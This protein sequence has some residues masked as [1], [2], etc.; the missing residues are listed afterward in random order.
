MK[1]LYTPSKIK[2]IET[3][4]FQGYLSNVKYNT[5][6]NK[7]LHLLSLY[8]RAVQTEVNDYE[9]YFNDNIDMKFY[10]FGQELEV[11]RNI[12]IKHLNRF[13]AYLIKFN[14]KIIDKN[15]SEIIKFNNQ[16]IKVKIDLVVEYSDKIELV[17]LSMSKPA[18]SY[19]ARNLDNIPENN[20]E[21][22]LMQLLGK[23][24]YVKAE[25]PISSAFYHMTGKFDGGKENK[26]NYNLFLN[27]EINVLNGLVD[28]QEENKRLA[29]NKR[30]ANKCDTVIKKL[31][32]II[33]FDGEKGSH[34]IRE[35]NFGVDYITDKL[36]NVFNVE[37]SMDSEK[38]VGSHC[39]MCQNYVLCQAQGYSK[40]ELEVVVEGDSGKGKVEATDSQLEFINSRDKYVR[41]NAVGGS[42]KTF[43]V[44][45]RLVE[46]LKTNDPSEILL[47]TFTNVGAEEMRTK[48]S[49]LTD[50]NPKDMNI[51]TFNSLGMYIIENE[52][53]VLG[54][55]AQPEL[56]N[57]IDKIDY[58][59][60]LLNRDEYKNLEWLNYKYPMLNMPNAKGAV[61]QVLNMFDELQ[62][63]T[64]TINSDVDESVVLDIYRDYG[65]ILLENNQLDYQDQLI[66]AIDALRD[67]EDILEKYGFKF[68]LVDEYNDVNK[69]QVDFLKIL[70]L[71]KTFEGLAILGD[72]SQSVFAFN[73]TSPK[74]MINFKDYFGEFTDIFILDNFR[75][76]SEIC[77][78]CN[79]YIKL[80][81]NRV[82]K[83][84][85]SVRGK[86]GRVELLKYNTIEDE[87][88]SIAVMIEQESTNYSDYAILGRTSKE[89]L[90]LKK[91]LDGKNIP[92][93]LAIPQK[94]MDNHNIRLIINLVKY[95]NG[96]KLEDG[97][98]DLDKNDYYLFEYVASTFN[99][100]TVVIYEIIVNT[101]KDEVK[102]Y[103]LDDELGEFSIFN[104]LIEELTKDDKVAKIF[105]NN[106]LEERTWSSFNEFANHL[107]KHVKYND[108]SQSEK[109][110][111]KYNAVILSTYHSS[112][113]KE[114]PKVFML[115]DKFNYTL[116]TE[117]DE[118]EEQRRLAYVGA[119]RSM[120]ELYMVYNTNEEAKRNKG[121]YPYI[122]DE[123]K[124]ILPSQIKPKGCWQSVNTV[125]KCDDMIMGEERS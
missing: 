120:N 108:I 43:A 91:V 123:I 10:T 63:G 64:L 106:L 125:D 41:V 35:F 119:S 36:N 75:S 122:V 86:G 1:M 99:N 117:Q 47:I 33:D 83:E 37:L 31:K 56:I 87:Y 67:N 111:I 112:K 82:D 53:D 55:T 81:E 73:F 116:T 26:D 38:C 95:I 78:L 60:E 110:D 21:L 69:I 65:E 90:T 121:K 27:G 22:Y 49:K 13:K 42:G 118:L 115:L 7:Y 62:R 20:F 50:V 124:N 28:E 11:D 44:I 30:A 23:D 34:I 74:F 66:L 113:G 39:S 48:L 6:Q 88:N 51:F 104:F 94:H 103:M 45:N 85:K 93:K 17:K 29:E 5:E 54:F 14:G 79:K 57:K 77:D 3:C 102:L 72:D 25:K 46:L 15:I 109:D 52:W 58:I 92:S 40:V 70:E 71:A 114:F 97:T 76:Y 19:N 89:L 96:I 107:I 98:L 4:N 68:I 61:Y 2:S 12:F 80:N 16:D 100:D 84:I 59:I 24:I 9:T 18:L 32:G 105:I 101:V 8:K